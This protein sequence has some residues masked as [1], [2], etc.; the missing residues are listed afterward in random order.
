M[1]RTPPHPEWQPKRQIKP[2]TDLGGMHD[3]HGG[4]PANEPSDVIICPYTFE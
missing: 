4:H 1:R 3:M 2:G